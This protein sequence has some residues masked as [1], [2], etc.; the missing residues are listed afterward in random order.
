MRKE[1]KHKRGLSKNKTFITKKNSKSKVKKV[2]FRT[3]TINWNSIR[4]TR[5]I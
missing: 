2:L 3:L 1:K 5:Q 4:K